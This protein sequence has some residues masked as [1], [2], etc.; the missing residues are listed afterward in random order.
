MQE[1]ATHPPAAGGMSFR[2]VPSD[3]QRR[4][5]EAVREADNR[6]LA[7]Q[8][9]RMMPKEEQERIDRDDYNKLRSA[10]TFEASLDVATA[11]AM[12]P[13]SRCWSAVTSLATCC[14]R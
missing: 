8:S 1:A 11:K 7:L 12:T 14:S 3:E 9:F 6:R 10:N 2:M 4:A 5:D 13:R